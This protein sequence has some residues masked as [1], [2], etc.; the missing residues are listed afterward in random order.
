M[1]DRCDTLLPSFL[2]LCTTSR[3]HKIVER[4]F[5]LLLVVRLAM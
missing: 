4:I 2:S 5:W 3:G 1:E